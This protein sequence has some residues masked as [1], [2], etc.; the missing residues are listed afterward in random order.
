MFLFLWVLF[1][2]AWYILESSFVLGV[3]LVLLLTTFPIIKLF[4]ST[5]WRKAFLPW[6]F[7]AIVQGVTLSAVMFFFTGGI[8]GL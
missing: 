2:V 6:L 5:T 8:G 4:Y 1:F 7:S 3:W